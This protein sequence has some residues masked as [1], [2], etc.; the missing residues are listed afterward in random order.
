[1]Q[2]NEEEMKDLMN[3]LS[4]EG[5]Q[6]SPEREQLQMD[7]WKQWKETDDDQVMSELLDSLTPLFKSNI[8]KYTQY[9]IPYNVLLHQAMVHARNAL[10]KYDPEKAKMN[11]FLTSQLQ[12]LDRFVKKYQNVAY[13]PE[14]LAQQFGRFEYAEQGLVHDLGRAPT[15]QEIS[16]KM[17][18]PTKHVERIQ[19]AKA[20]TKFMSGMPESS[21]DELEGTTQQRLQDNLQYLREE[22]SG[23]EL[24]AFDSLSGV[25]G[26]PIKAQAVAKNLGVDVQQ[27]YTWRR[28][29]T[30]ILSKY[31]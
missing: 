31:M 26:D 8:Q 14:F 25:S 4:K 5:A 1:M 18:I 28:R 12:P 16:D 9:P 23:S 13:L 22:L 6:I 17:V 27:V 3:R 21:E 24:K 15:I 7:L 19:A 30:K 11:T 29:W 20:N 10:G 2:F